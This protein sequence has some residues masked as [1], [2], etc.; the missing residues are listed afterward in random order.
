MDEQLMGDGRISGLKSK[1]NL[2]R[3]FRLGR[4]MKTRGAVL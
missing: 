1:T 2:N 3:F 4:E